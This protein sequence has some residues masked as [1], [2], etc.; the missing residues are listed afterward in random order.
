MRVSSKYVLLNLAFSII[1]QAGGAF[2]SAQDFGGLKVSPQNAQEITRLLTQLRTASED[3][4]R[5]GQTTTDGDGRRLFAGE[6][7][8]RM[9]RLHDETL[10]RIDQMIARPEGERRAAVAAIADFTAD[11]A[12]ALSL[13][14][15]GQDAV[16]YIRTARSSYN[17]AQMVEIYRAGAAQVEV[18]PLNNHL[19]QFGPRPL[20]EDNLKRSDFNFTPRY[21]QAELSVLA[22][23]ILK[24][25]AAG[26]DVDALQARE[27]NKEGLV[28]FFRWE[29]MS[30]EVEGI[31]PFVQ[32]G[33][34]RAG[35]LV[36]YTNT[37]GLPDSPAPATVSL[38]NRKGEARFLKA[39]H[40]TKLSVLSLMQSATGVWIFAN[41]G[42]YY[43]EYGPSAY[44][45]T[46]NNEGYCSTRIASWCNPKYM[47]YTY[48][49]SSVSN[50]ATWWH[51]GYDGGWGT[52]KVFIPRVNATTRQSSYFISYS[53]GSSY[54][55]SIDQ[56]SY[57]DVWI[58]TNT[59]Y[60]IGSTTLYDTPWGWGT[61]AG[62]K[63]GFDEIQIVY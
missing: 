26:L 42:G 47:K 58:T 32:V 40:G 22:R 43:S 14:A 28:Y 55:F 33:I 53:G 5:N 31:H 7:A 2:V 51:P 63:V 38:E 6:S 46:T 39:A 30:K 25:R 16:E 52:H 21:G 18:N 19:V 3:E 37:L 56:L 8:V 62:K 41:N 1:F 60:A 20:S 48:E 11:P 13:R 35:E 15:D 59:L 12:I 61:P 36:S 44:W 9:K 45:W 34:T 23:K 27:S 29:D 10:K 17:R 49:S 24:R 4:L 54:S 50:Y 57:S